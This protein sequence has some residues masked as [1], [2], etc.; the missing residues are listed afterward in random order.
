MKRIATV[1]FSFTTFLGA[2]AAWL[3]LGA[4]FSAFDLGTLP[5]LVLW[6]QQL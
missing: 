6:R 3:P 1:L 2:V 5:T 4:Q